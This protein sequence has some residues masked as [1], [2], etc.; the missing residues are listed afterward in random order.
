MGTSPKPPPLL[1][2][3]GNEVHD[4]AGVTFIQAPRL[5]RETVE[6]LGARPPHPAGS[7]FFPAGQKIQRRPHAN[8]DG[9]PQRPVGHGDPF[10]LFRTT[11]GD[12]K[13]VRLR[14]L[15]ATKD[16]VVVHLEQG[17]ERRRIMAHDLKKWI[18]LLKAFGG[19]RSHAVRGAEQK[20]P[21][22]FFRG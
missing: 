18:L 8:G 22:S 4:I 21:I 9:H 2:Q 6:P 11:K 19:G 10:F 13:D 16:L 12:E 15:D 14:R 20:D 17:R 5:L 7:A 1:R 3:Q